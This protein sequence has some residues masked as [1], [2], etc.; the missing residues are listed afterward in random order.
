MP[1]LT[2]FCMRIK[3]QLDKISKEDGGRNP[4]QGEVSLTLTQHNEGAR[5]EAYLT[6]SVRITLSDWCVPVKWSGG[7]SDMTLVWSWHSCSQLTVIGVDG[8]HSTQPASHSYFDPLFFYFCPL[9][10]PVFCLLAT[11]NQG[12]GD[13]GIGPSGI[14]H[15]EPGQ[16]ECNNWELDSSGAG[17]LACQVGNDFRDSSAIMQPG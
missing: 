13:R 7:L 16:D 6:T 5:G 15:Q 10:S 3:K 2:C 8:P 17:H 1:S 11:S 12:F 14:N 4:W 9:F